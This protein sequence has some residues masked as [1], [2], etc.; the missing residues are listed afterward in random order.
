VVGLVLVLLPFLDRRA[1]WGKWSRWPA[2]FGIALL[3]YSV[4]LTIW[5]YT[6][7]ATK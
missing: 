3:V 7:S 1:A 2:A 4:V 5:G 6:M